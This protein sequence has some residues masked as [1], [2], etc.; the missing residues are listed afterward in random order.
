M[1]D[2]L[3]IAGVPSELQA[4]ALACVAKAKQNNSGLTLAKWKVRLFK[5]GKIADLLDWTDERLC[6]KHPE[7]ADEDIAPMDNITCNGDMIPWYDTP[8]GGRP[9]RSYWLDK[10][11]NSD[12]YKAAVAANHRY[13]PGV[14]PRSRESR[15][16]WYRRNGGE[17]RAWRVGAN[18]DTSNNLEIWRGS[19]GKTDVIVTRCGDVWLINASSKI[20]GSLH[21][22]TRVGFELD[23]VFCGDYTPQMWWP[24]KGFLLRATV[25]YGILPSFKG[26]NLSPKRWEKLKVTDSKSYSVTT[27]I[28]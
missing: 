16:A 19:N 20:I 17:Y 6:I 27:L 15:K 4:E 23:N 25:T 9:M 26:I 18:V 22:H 11:P 21:L 8:D 5:A 3:T 13:C 7:L 28:K 10:D 2:F 14:H 24:I 1:N 12:D